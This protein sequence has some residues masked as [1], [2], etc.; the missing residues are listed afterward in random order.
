MNC[1]EFENLLADALGNELAAEDRPDFEAHRA[2]CER[3]RREYESTRSA[4]ERMR[5][6]TGPAA[7]DVRREGDRLVIAPGTP[8]TTSPRRV[9]IVFR[10][11]AAVL[12]AFAAGYLSRGASST[13]RP[14]TPR[15]QRP[16]EEP[17]PA[18]ASRKPSLRLALADAYA[19]H[20]DR[21]ELAGCLS[22]LFGGGTN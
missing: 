19:K 2:T 9:P 14:E 16:A 4:I 1:E 8:A 10:Y 18:A 21:S 11:A 12:I 5:D 3:C 22:A 20:R 6:L 13:V 7:V 15:V 17:L